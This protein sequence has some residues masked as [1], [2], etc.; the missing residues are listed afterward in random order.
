MPRHHE[1]L[2][3]RHAK[4]PAPRENNPQSAAHV[5]HFADKPLKIQVRA[6]AACTLVILNAI[7]PASI[8]LP[9]RP[10]RPRFVPSLVLRSLGTV[11]VSRR[12]PEA[13]LPEIQQKPAL[14]I[15]KSPF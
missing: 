8:E 9:Q 1:P 4:F 12:D 7:I 3:R 14:P 13:D 2:E 6:S 10:T 15:Q 11:Q 5:P